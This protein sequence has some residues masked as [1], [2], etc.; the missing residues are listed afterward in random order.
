MISNARLTKKGSS[1]LWFIIGLILILNDSSAGWIFFIIGL[2]SL[3]DQGDRM[4]DQHP[5]MIATITIV[6]LLLVLSF[7]VLALLFR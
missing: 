1:T 2:I 5:R 3:S 6:L 7:S 4:A